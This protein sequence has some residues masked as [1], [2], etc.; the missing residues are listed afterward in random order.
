MG[1]EVSDFCGFSS[2]ISDRSAANFFSGY[3]SDSRLKSSLAK[4]SSSSL[5]SLGTEI[6]S[7]FGFSCNLGGYSGFLFP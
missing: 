4:G 2:V 7:S 5:L 3:S 1:L 6:I